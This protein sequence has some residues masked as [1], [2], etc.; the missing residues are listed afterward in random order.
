[1]KFDRICSRSVRS[2]IPLV[3]VT[4]R[5]TLQEKIVEPLLDV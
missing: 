1:M 3:E 2:G 5:E 4:N